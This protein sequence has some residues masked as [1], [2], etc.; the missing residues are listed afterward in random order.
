VLAE[1]HYSNLSP[2]VCVQ[3]LILLCQATAKPGDVISHFVFPPA[4][5]PIRRL[6]ALRGT[7]ARGS[8]NGIAEWKRTGIE[9]K[10]AR[11]RQCV[12]FTRRYFL[13][14]AKVQNGLRKNSFRH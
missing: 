1:F 12:G 13:G 8:F 2:T 14:L 6:V 9:L 5:Q 4:V 10:I 11:Q 3:D 7:R